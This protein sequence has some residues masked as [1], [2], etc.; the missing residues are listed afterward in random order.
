MPL[1]ETT[2]ELASRYRRDGFV[3][4]LV[5][6]DA[7]RVATCADEVLE[8]ADGGG[9]SLDVPW[10]QKTYLLLPCLD[11]LVRD[12]ALTDQIAEILG[13]DLL[14]LSADVFLKQ[15]HTGQHISWHQDVNYWDLDPLEVATAWIALTAS[16]TENGCMRYAKG[17]H[18]ERLEHTERPSPDNMLTRGQEIEVDVDEAAAVDVVLEPGQVSVHH[19]LTP[20]ASGPNQS[21]EVRIGL[22]VRYAPPSI[23][24]RSGPRISARRARG[25]DHDHHFELEDGPEAPMSPGAVL[26]HRRALSPHAEE[27]YSTV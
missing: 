13:P 7:E 14:V 8:L 12:P 10:H 11:Q 16:T 9:P 26:R 5:A 19:A 17:A 18:G 2:G 1:P 25:E 22:A 4:P 15:P 21:D 27:Q 24:Q 20:H 23:H 6:F 3:L